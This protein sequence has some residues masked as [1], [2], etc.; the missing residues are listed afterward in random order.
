ME[1]MRTF[2]FML[3]L[4]AIMLMTGC[5]EKDMYT[6]KA[7]VSGTS[8]ATY[9]LLTYTP[10]GPE[11]QLLASRKGIFE[12][13][14]TIS[15]P[16][17]VEIMTND[18]APLGVYWAAPD[19]EIEINVD[20]KDPGKFRVSGSEINDRLSKWFE[21]NQT[22]ISGG[23]SEKLNEAI[24]KYVRSNPKDQVSVILMATRWD[25]SI[26]PVLTLDLWNKIDRTIR[27]PY[28]GADVVKQ[29][30]YAAGP[31]RDKV[32]KE[33][34]FINQKDTLE[35]FKPTGHKVSVMAFSDETVMAD[36]DSIAK[37]FGELRKKHKSEKKLK[38]I[39]YSLDNDARAWR[40]AVDTDSVKY[41]LAWSGPGRGALGVAEL[42]IGRLPFFIVADST[43]RQIYRG[44]SI[45]VALDSVRALKP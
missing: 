7:S 27:L 45:D 1:M 32:L 29:A 33:M 24:E 11:M 42:A 19:D 13:R 18:Y 26:D 2:F 22:L 6:L 5:G 31:L 21:A 14:D 41:T 23:R 34:S 43:G 10:R 17:L 36:R 38:I 39:D 40:A 25:S 15:S 30:E 35:L 44:S 4:S 8:D 12:F 16:V 9:R 3:V 28:I 37:R 20:P